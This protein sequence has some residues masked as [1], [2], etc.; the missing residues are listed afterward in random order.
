MAECAKEKLEESTSDSS[1]LSRSVDSVCLD[2]QEASWIERDSGTSSDKTYTETDMESS[3][4]E[5]SNSSLS[6][7]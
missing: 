2:S 4:S 6:N 7:M 3:E 5:Y 1:A